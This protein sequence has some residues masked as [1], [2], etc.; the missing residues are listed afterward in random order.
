VTLLFAF[1][2]YGFF[3]FSAQLTLQHRN[4]PLRGVVLTSQTP[5]SPAAFFSSSTF[6]GLAKTFLMYKGIYNAQAHVPVDAAV[7]EIVDHMSKGGN[8]VPLSGVYLHHHGH[9]LPAKSA[10][11]S[12]RST[13]KGV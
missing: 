13:L 7:A 1:V 10:S 4:L 2:S 8:V 5:W 6:W 12:V 11:W 9:V 3:A